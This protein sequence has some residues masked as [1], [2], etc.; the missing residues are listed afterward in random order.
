MRTLSAFRGKLLLLHFFAAGSAQSERDLETLESRYAGW[1]AR[2]LQLLSVNVAG[3]SAVRANR[4]PF[5]IVKGSD[6]VAA[7]YNLLYR[8]VFERHRDLTLPTSFLIDEKS[9]VVKIYQG[10][11]DPDRVDDD[12]RRMPRSTAER[13][14]LALPF[15]GVADTYE[16]G[17]N[18]LAYG[19]VF[20]QRGYFDQAEEAFRLS[21][22][23]DAASAEAHYGLG[24]VFLKRGDAAA[25]RE[26][27]ERVLTLKASFPDT[28]PNAWNNLGLLATR[29]GKIDEA[30]RY[31]QQA[32]RVSPEHW[33]ALENLGNAYRQQHLWEQA[34]QT[35]EQ[36]LEARP[37][38]AEA[39]YSLAMV[40]AQTEQP[41]LALEHF[42]KALH[43]RPLYPEAL[44][45]L[46]ILYL[47]SGRRSEA[48][49]QFEE[50]IRV[51]PD[52]DQP[53]LNLAR[54]YAVEGTPDKARTLLEA[55][56]KQHPGHAQAQAA[57]DQ[58]R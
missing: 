11:I 6:D 3:G 57:L 24:S 58:L 31:F 8:Y 28:L 26:S 34:R 53:Y 49:E 54:V 45:N 21:L 32:L 23:D 18:H 42:Q 9:S 33:I 27:F 50:C 36:A 12:L 10:P 43:Y 30:I 5:P 29:E 15:P 41:D 13:L 38:D 16:F 25:A 20:F 2:G 19:S 55:L 51:A 47:R 35:L 46:G 17:R 52:F 7:V 39:N 56:L 22:A 4:L 44:N 37:E 1:V 14:K 48:V 40:Y